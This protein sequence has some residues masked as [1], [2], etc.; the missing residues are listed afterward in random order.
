MVDANTTLQQEK[1]KADMHREIANLEAIERREAEFQQLQEKERDRAMVAQQKLRELAAQELKERVHLERELVRQQQQNLI[2]QKQREID[3]LEAQA[4][5]NLFQ[6]AQTS[7]GKPAHKEKLATVQEEP[8]IPS[9]EGAVVLTDSDT[10]PPSQ[11]RPKPAKRLPVA[12]DACT[13]VSPVS[14]SESLALSAVSVSEGPMLALATGVPLPTSHGPL[15]IP[16]GPVVAATPQPLVNPDVGQAMYTAGAQPVGS[17][18][19]S[20]PLG[21]PVSHLPTCLA[22]YP[23]YAQQCLAPPLVPGSVLPAPTA[24]LY[25]GPVSTCVTSTPPT[26]VV[27]SMPSSVVGADTRPTYISLGVPVTSAPPIVDTK[28]CAPC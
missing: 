8:A 7:S 14:A 26:S 25:A 2:L 19:G 5:R 6:Q 13:Q 22:T 10:P 1:L 18:I 28:G 12:V 27:A 16:R 9:P 20:K 11:N 24:S 23:A 4:D 17:L 15:V 21:D 3:R